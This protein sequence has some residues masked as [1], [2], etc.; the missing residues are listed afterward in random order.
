MAADDVAAVAAVRIV[1]QALRLTTSPEHPARTEF[2]E[3]AGEEYWPLLD[4]PDAVHELFCVVMKK[5]I[6]Q[7]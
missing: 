3:L 5:F 7:R 1:A 6:G 2:A 4:D